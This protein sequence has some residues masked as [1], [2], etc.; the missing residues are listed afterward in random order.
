[1]FQDLSSYLHVAL[2]KKNDENDTLN[3]NYWSDEFDRQLNAYSNIEMFESSTNH[4]LSTEILH[5]IGVKF[6]SKLYS[7]IQALKNQYML[8]LK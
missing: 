3:C 5:S 8:E 6:F 1:M 4:T 2:L 7:L